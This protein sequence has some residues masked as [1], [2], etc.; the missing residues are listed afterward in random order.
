MREL[1]FDHHPY[2]MTDGEKDVSKAMLCSML[3]STCNLHLGR[4]ERRLREFGTLAYFYSMNSPEYIARVLEYIRQ[5]NYYQLLINEWHKSIVDKDELCVSSCHY[6]MSLASTS[7][8]KM[9]K[10]CNDQLERLRK[11]NV[12]ITKIPRAKKT[13]TWVGL[14]KGM[15]ES[16][17]STI[18][19]ARRLTI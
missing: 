15:T 11:N 9:I 10:V 14:T 2:G 19:I 7:Q 18:H 12:E 1:S 16:K 17:V 6:G 13:K 3:C 4:M 5:K 8:Q